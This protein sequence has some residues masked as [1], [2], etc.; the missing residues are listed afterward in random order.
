MPRPTTT[1]NRRQHAAPDGNRANVLRLDGTITRIARDKGY[2]FIKGE[3][4]K[5]Y[6]FHM[7]GA[8]EWP[9]LTEGMLVAFTVVAS[10]KGPRAE[11]VELREG[12]P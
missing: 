4:H 8:E 3:D 7:S 5:Q 6:F 9:S 10:P 12:R 2:G 11:D 1:D